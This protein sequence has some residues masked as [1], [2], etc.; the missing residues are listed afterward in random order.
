M[1]MLALIVSAV[2]VGQ[3]QVPN[4]F[5]TRGAGTAINADQA[6]VLVGDVVHEQPQPL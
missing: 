6:L 4:T 5:F 2:A 3:T 1:I